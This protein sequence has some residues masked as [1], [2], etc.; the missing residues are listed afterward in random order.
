MYLIHNENDVI[1]V[2]SLRRNEYYFFIAGL[3]VGFV[4]GLADCDLYRGETGN[5]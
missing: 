5:R 1:G 2:T 4:V 3:F